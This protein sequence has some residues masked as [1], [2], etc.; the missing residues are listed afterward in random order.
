MTR[1][2]RVTTGVVVLLAV[3]V[4]VGLAV[5]ADRST[6]AW[7][8]A[9]RSACRSVQ[10]FTGSVGSPYNQFAGVLRARLQA[11]PEHFDVDV[12]QT[13]GSTDNLYDLQSADPP[14]CALAIAQLNTT[15]DAAEGVNQFDP[16]RGGQKV[17]GLRTLGPVHQ[18]LLHVIVRDRPRGPADAPVRG[19]A[20][21]CHRTIAAGE[22][23][24]GTRQIADVLLR[25]GLPGCHPDLDPSNLDNALR[26]LGAGRVDA[27]VWAGGPGTR[28]IRAAINGGARLRLLDLSDQLAGITRDWNVFYGG[29]ERSYPGAVFGAGGL[30]P[31]DYP[32]IRPIR[33]ITIPNGLIARV[34]T[35]PVL[36]RRA[37]A[38]LFRRPA[39]FATAL[40]Q[41]NPA[42]HTIPDALSIYEGPLFCYIPLHPAAAEYYL[43]QFR[44]A[45]SCGT[46]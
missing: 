29:R 3:A 25:V 39:D 34:D 13:A 22:A 30:G 19:L 41:T 5:T 40:W 35:D 1:R 12:V 27:V 43:R 33:T 2:Q 10:I 37:T 15:V 8:P 45:P 20:D 44:R 28:Q 7:P 38:E 4:A 14:R 18:D 46:T 31:A 11:A 9:G 23:N 24:S 26:L 6:A 21:L 32:G 36:V 17:T 42:H 16:T